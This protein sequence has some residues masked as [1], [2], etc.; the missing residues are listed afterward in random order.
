MKSAVGQL[1]KL[2]ALKRHERPEQA[3]WHAFLCEFHQHQR[4][5][6]RKSGLSSFLSHLSIWFAD[7]S[8]SKRI[9]GGGLAYATVAAAMLLTPPPVEKENPAVTSVSY[10][11]VPMPES[12]VVEQPEPADPRPRAQ[13]RPDDPVF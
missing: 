11:V 7:L 1:E 4:E 2:L 13:G 5:R 3:Y 9:Y 10:Q 8:P 6:V 12:S